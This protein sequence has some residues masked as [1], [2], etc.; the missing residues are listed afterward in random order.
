[1]LW[2]PVLSAYFYRLDPSSLALTR[3]FPDSA[4][5]ATSVS[6]YTSFLYYN[7]IWGDAQ[8]PDSNPLQKTIPRFG[9]RRFVSGPTGPTDKQLL[10]KGLFPD[11]RGKKSWLQWGVA[12]YMS[13]YPCCIRGWRI[14]MSGVVLVGLL[15]SAVYGVRVCVRKYRVK[16]YTKVGT[17]I[18][19]SDL[20]GIEEGISY[21]TLEDER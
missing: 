5:S 12:L 10:R 16:G 13:W 6:N 7:G 1:M 20:S 17:E 11:H 14:W 3:I 15:V 21:D 2:D 19:M 9:L 18:P 8:Y 4:D